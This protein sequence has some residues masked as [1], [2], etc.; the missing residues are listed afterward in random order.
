MTYTSLWNTKTILLSLTLSRTNLKPLCNLSANNNGMRGVALLP[1]LPLWDG[2]V[3]YP[4]RLPTHMWTG[5]CRTAA[6]KEGSDLHYPSSRD[7]PEI[8]L[9]ASTPSID[10]TVAS[11]ASGSVY[12][13][14]SQPALAQKRTRIVLWLSASLAT[15]FAMVLATCLRM[16][17]PTTIPLTPPSGFLRPVCRL[18]LVLT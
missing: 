3:D 1:S 11:S 15:Y 5:C 14:H 17:S 18:H 6:P 8:K 7:P 16:M 9:H 4:S 12:A 13:T 10:T 2:P